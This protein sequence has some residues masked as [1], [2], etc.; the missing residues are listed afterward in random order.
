MYASSGTYPVASILYILSIP[1]NYSGGPLCGLRVTSEFCF[2]LGKVSAGGSANAAREGRMDPVI[3]IGGGAAGLIAAW[4]CAGRGVPTLLLEKNERLG[5]K[6]HISGGGK[7]NITH[8]GPMDDVRMAFEPHEAR[9]L[10]APFLRFS[11]DDVLALLH[12]RGVETYARPDGRVFPISGRA[13]DVVDALAWHAREAGAEIRCDAPVEGIE[14]VGGHV[15]SVRSHGRELPAAAVILATGGV[16]YPK[17]GTTGDG[18]RW[19]RELGHMLVP[20]RAALAPIYLEPPPP[21]GWSGVAL[22]D[23]LLR[24]RAGGKTI[25]RWRGDLLFTHKGISGPTALGIS[26]DVA[27]A[28]ERGPVTLDVD[29]LPDGSPD[30]LTAELTSTEHR[31]ARRGVRTLLEAW[32]PN[33]IVPAF[34]ERAGID[35]GTPLHQLSRSGRNRLIETLKGWSL[36]P[37][38]A[39]PLERGEVTAGGVALEEVDPATMASRKTSGLYLCGEILD[40]AGPVGGYNLQ[41][42]FSTGYVAGEAAAGR[43]GLDMERG[44]RGGAR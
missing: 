29:L 5:I 1:V 36:G 22:R 32:L 20:L 21:D 24:A 19:A 17:T 10:R 8:A 30:D 15:R 18:F 31:S 41:A 4:R 2:L 34:L 11:N 9:F 39:V 28:L 42:A 37:A 6:L 3:V 7:C 44:R 23:C 43:M 35:P 40:I 12:A 16:S 38:R 27:L 25:S 13:D 33:R 14:T 26:R